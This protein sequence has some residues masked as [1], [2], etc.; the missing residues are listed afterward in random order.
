MDPYLAPIERP[1]GVVMRLI[2]FLS[3]RFLGKV[4]TPLSVSAARMP[5]G[6]LLFSTKIAR[7][8]R[9]LTLPASTVAL[10]RAQVTSVNS[11]LFCMDVQRW[12]VTKKA[13][14]TLAQLD[15]LPE[16]ETSRLFSAADRAALDYATELTATKSVRRET[17]ARLAEHFNDREICDIVWCVASE[18][19]YN[20]SNHGLG[21]GS[22]GFCELRP[23]ATAAAETRDEAHEVVA[24]R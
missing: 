1:K 18:H 10:V 15:A 13:P 24:A 14:E 12:F 8:D 22:D 16:Y 6:F 23:P 9:K 17:F 20:I 2:Y 5:L 11:C 4:P 3:K 7:L 21:I 19:L